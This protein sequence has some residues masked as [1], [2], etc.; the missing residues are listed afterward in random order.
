[1]AALTLP[2]MARG[3]AA[4]RQSVAPSRAEAVVVGAGFAGLS[5]ARH[6]AAAGVDVVVLEARD[7][8]GGR[9]LNKDLGNGEIVEAGGQYIGPTQDRMAAL[10]QELEV[11]TY[12]TYADG[13][14]ATVVGGE[15]FVGGFSP[16]L[17]AEYHTL[18]R[19]LNLMAE[20]VPVD[21]PWTAPLARGWDG[22]TLHSWLVSNGASPDG[23]AIFNSV[24]DLWGAEARDVSLL[25]ALFLHC[26][27]RQRADARHA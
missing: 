26:R 13:D 16:T 7:R 3:A 1:M 10:A 23:L 21:A 24:S 27:R 9:I 20:T 19:Q 15:R 4:S 6:L 12:P 2:P 17:R 11:D 25:F 5:A 18:A 22:Q 8:V 14:D